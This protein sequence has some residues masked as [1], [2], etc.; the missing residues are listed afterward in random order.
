MGNCK[1]MATPMNNNLKKVTASNSKLVN[2]TLYM[3]LIGNF[4]T[5]Y[6]EI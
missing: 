2:P 5:V 6:S 4:D 1:P 3:Q